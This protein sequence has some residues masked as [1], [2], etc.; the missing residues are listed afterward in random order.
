MPVSIRTLLEIVEDLKWA[1]ME[2]SVWVVFG[3]V[4]VVII[5]TAPKLG[6]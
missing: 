3:V 5:I 2:P 6:D 1:V 4:A